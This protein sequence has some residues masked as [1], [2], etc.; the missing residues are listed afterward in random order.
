MIRQYC[1]SNL[2]PIIQ[3]VIGLILKNSCLFIIT[4]LCLFFL[5][6]A[7]AASEGNSYIRNWVR[8]IETGDCTRDKNCLVSSVILLPELYKKYNFRLIWTNQISVRQLIDAIKDSYHDGLV[9]EDYHLSHIQELQRT[10]IVKPDPVTQ[11]R[12]DIILTDSLIRL[13][14]HLLMGKVD[15]ESL[16][17][18]WN[19]TRP[20]IEMNATLKMSVYIDNAQITKLIAGFRPQADSYHELKRA[21]ASYRK[22]QA[23]GGWPLVPAKGILNSGMG[24]QGVLTIRRRLAATGDIPESDMESALYDNEFKDGIKRFQQRH[25]LEVNGLVDKITLSAMNIPVEVRIDQL[26]VNLDRARWVL[27]NLPQNFV[28]VDIAGFNVQYI[29][30]D[31]LA[32]KTRAIVGS[33]YRKTPIFRSDIRFII[34]NP[35]WTVPPTILKEDILPKIKQNPEYLRNKNM[36]VLSQ[37]G[38]QIDPSTID[39]TQYPGIS[40]PY[41]IRQ[42]S[43]PENTLGQ[44]KF[45]FPNKH[46]VYLHDTSKKAGFKRIERALSSGCIRIQNPLHFAKL[47]LMDKPGWDR[48]KINAIVES[49]EQTHVNLS[50]PLKIIFLYRTAEVDHEHRVLFK[51]DIYDRDSAVIAGLKGKFKFRDSKIIE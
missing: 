27:R 32:W 25:S 49:R 50:R 24:D 18:N 36:V 8:N 14:Y 45:M 7:P 23:K 13:G 10:L 47:L 48:E 35:T 39:W 41:L 40:F 42:R 17:S 26:R 12:L 30:S 46:A 34:F 29:R 22:I 6:T 4:F 1:R 2:L 11:A 37:K 51:Q 28:V 43:G 31:Q 44:V 21:L 38:I 9:P 15:P 16:D 3:L 19:M 33:S 5:Q 20:L